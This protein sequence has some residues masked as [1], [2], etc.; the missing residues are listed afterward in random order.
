MGLTWVLYS[1]WRPVGAAPV[2]YRQ[3]PK[4][5]ISSTVAQDVAPRHAR[6]LRPGMVATDLQN[7]IAS[8]LVD[9]HSTRVGAFPH[10]AVFIHGPSWQVEPP[11]NHFDQK[12]VV[13]GGEKATAVPPI[14]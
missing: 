8:S 7:G 4:I 13:I 12:K 9:L 6:H 3:I 10:S 11:D 1:V 2:D 5:K 14:V